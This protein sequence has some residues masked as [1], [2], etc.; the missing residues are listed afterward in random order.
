MM[1]KCLFLVM[2]LLIS[3]PVL[4]AKDK[5]EDYK[6]VVDKNENGIYLYEGIVTVEGIDK[7]EMFKRAKNWIVSNLKTEDNNISFDETNMHIANTANIVLKPGSGFNWNI[8]HMVVNFKLNLMFKDGR[9]KFVFDNIVVQAASA[10][11]GLET[12]S[13][14]QITRNNKPSKHA[15]KEVNEKLLAISTQLE[16]AIKTGVEKGKDDW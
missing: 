8:S 16:Q 3:I 12:L 5:E 6:V 10:N 1:K 7:A 15:R 13:Y 14:E 11:I 4:Q 9:Y 2:F